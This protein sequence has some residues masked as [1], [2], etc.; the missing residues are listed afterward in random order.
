MFTKQKFINDLGTFTTRKRVAEYL[1]Y[2]DPH[3][4]DRF[5]RGLERV[6]G[7]RYMSADVYER[8]V[9]EGLS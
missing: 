7:T 8:I 9:K 5:L 4:V 1:G 2:K 3:S 6:A